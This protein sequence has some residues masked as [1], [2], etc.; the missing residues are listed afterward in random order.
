MTENAQQGLGGEPQTTTL[1]V[2]FDFS[3]S[4][5]LALDQALSMASLVPS[6]R[7][8]VV[9]APKKYGG[10]PGP[11]AAQDLDHAV[12]LLRARIA[13]RVEDLNGFGVSF[14]AARVTARVQEGS[15]ARVITQLAF[16]E[17]AHLIVVGSSVKTGI[18][19]VMLGDVAQDV[20][21]KAPC[22]VLVARARA[23][24]GLPEVDPPHEEAGTAAPELKE[25]HTYRARHHEQLPKRP[26]EQGPGFS[27]IFPLS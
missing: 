25:R 20:L 12:Q 19:R 9:W 17:G 11:G 1:I 13:E 18:E 4:A 16:T 22:P 23:V 3:D 24:E 8:H 26:R 15:P 5:E 27:L 10:T 7:L 6:S 14:P 21:A 2:G